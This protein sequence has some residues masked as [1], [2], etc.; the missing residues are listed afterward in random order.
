M[1]YIV[2]GHSDPWGSRG[3][4]I[5]VPKGFTVNL[6][7]DF[8]KNISREVAQS[9]DK[10]LIFNRYDSVNSKIVKSVSEGQNIRNYPCWNYTETY[11][12]I[13]GISMQQD[14]IRKPIIDLSKYTKDSPLS[15]KSMFGM[16]PEPG[17][18]YWITCSYEKF[19][20]ERW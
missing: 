7:I 20:K 16:L 17:V 13:P 8:P 19:F 15:L 11:M 1:Y 9:I 18:I 2:S 4:D 3:S 5:L 6:F 12:G 14:G 10:D